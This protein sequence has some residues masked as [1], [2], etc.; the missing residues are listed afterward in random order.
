MGF[1]SKTRPAPFG[2]SN[3]WLDQ[4]DDE[5]RERQLE[6]IAPASM[7]RNSPLYQAQV[8]LVKHLQRQLAEANER[9]KQLESGVPAKK[10]KKP[11]NYENGKPGRPIAASVEI[12]E[13]VRYFSLRYVAELRGINQSNVSRQ[14]TKSGIK[15]KVIGGIYYIPAAQAENIYN[16]K[17]KR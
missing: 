11:R 3:D 14:V 1:N 9:I 6:E 16:K 13:G 5:L 8:N 4:R 15:P 2:V 12:V 17:R 7:V 10:G